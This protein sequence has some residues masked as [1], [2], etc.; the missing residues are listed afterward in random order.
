MTERKN[1]AV[2]LSNLRT[3]RRSIG[4]AGRR[5]F[6]MRG[7]LKALI[8]VW[9][10][11]AHRNLSMKPLHLASLSSSSFLRKQTHDGILS[12]RGSWRSEKSPN[13][14][15]FQRETQNVRDSEGRRHTVSQFTKEQ[16][17]KPITIIGSI[18]GLNLHSSIN[19]LINL[20]WTE[21]LFWGVIYFVQVKL[22]R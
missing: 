16:K 19:R 9:L 6:G 18:P 11:P 14:P 15:K 5:G 12:R 2:F 17:K 21:N 1:R 3:N 4:A 10:L 13:V 7:A 20:L 8:V 22:K